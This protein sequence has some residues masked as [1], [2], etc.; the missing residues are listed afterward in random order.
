M[1]RGFCLRNT[2]IRI[3]CVDIF[4]SVCKLNYSRNAAV[5]QNG[6]YREER[7]KSV[8]LELRQV[9]T[10]RKRYLIFD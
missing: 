5:Q 10:P 1:C 9:S 4:V 2:E 7:N 3:D 6:K 8:L